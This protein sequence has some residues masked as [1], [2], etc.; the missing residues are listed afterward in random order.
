LND[1]AGRFADAARQFGLDVV[2]PCMAGC[3]LDYDL[4]GHLDLYL[5]IN[6]DCYKQSPNIPFYATNAEPNRL[7]HNIAGRKFEDVSESAGIGTTGWTLAVAAGDYDGDGDADIGVANDFG[8]KV[9]YRNNGNGTF[10]D[11]AKQAGV[12][13]FS[14]GMGLA[15][16][17][18]NDDGHLDL[19]TSNINSNQRW[20]GEESTLWQY[21]RNIVRTKYVFEDFKHFRELYGLLDDDWRSLGKQIGEGNSLFYNNQD[22]TFRELKDSHTNRAGWSWGVAPCDFDND[23]D[24]DIYVCNGWVSGPK[25]DD[26]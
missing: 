9:L 19:Y 20:F 2:A 1:G 14:G 16:G 21:C 25:T 18:F 24:L 13:D 17:D 5:G 10:T 4:D 7:F 12:L 23:S 15:F 6:G 8:R 22:A 26:L 11:V 3:V